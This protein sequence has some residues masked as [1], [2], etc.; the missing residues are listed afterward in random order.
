MPQIASERAAFAPRHAAAMCLAN[1]NGKRVK[2]IEEPRPLRLWIASKR[3]P[4]EFGERI[5]CRPPLC[6]WMK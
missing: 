4:R 5:V 6:D 1:R 3:L 2:L